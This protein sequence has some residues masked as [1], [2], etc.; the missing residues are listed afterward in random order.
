MK[1]T[2]LFA[3]KESLRNMN[4]Y[5]VKKNRALYALEDRDLKL[6]KKKKKSVSLQKYR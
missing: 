5:R 4:Q 2:A 3:I 1:N 6:K